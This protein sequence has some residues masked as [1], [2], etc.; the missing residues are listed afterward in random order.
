MERAHDSVST[1]CDITPM[2]QAVQAPLPENKEAA[3]QDLK[4]IEGN[5]PSLPPLDGG[6]G[7]LVILGAF[8]I[9]GVMQDMYE[10]IFQD[11]E[12]V[13]LKLS[14][15]GTIMEAM[16]NL[17]GLVATIILARFGMRVL[18]FSGSFLAVLGLEMAGFATQIWHLYLCQGVV[19]NTAPKWF[20]KKRGLAMGLASSGSGFGGLILPFILNAANKNPALGVGWAYRI[21]GFIILACCIGACLLVKERVKTPKRTKSLKDLFDFSVLKD[22]NFLLW[23]LGSMIGLC[24]FFVPFFFLPSY[25]RH[26]GLDPDQGSALIAVLSTGNLLGRPLVGF[27]ADKIGRLNADIIWTIICGLSSLLIWTFADSYGVLMAFCIVFGLFCGSYFTLL[28]PITLDIVG[29]DRFPT[30]LSMLLMSNIFSVFGPSI[31]SGIQ[32][33]VDNPF[34]VY[35]IFTGFTYVLG[36]LILL[37]LKIKMTKGLWTRI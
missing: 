5:D 36:G 11:E 30:A 16:V 29:I 35:K 27:T 6:R 22:I 1:V 28:S 37:A 21:L 12:N 15:A 7:W 2:D 13:Q 10:E 25:A 4:D 8:F 18:L 32:V 23:T 20:D 19:M 3:H 24:G 17:C 14:F 33:Q 31:A 34:L 26:I 9:Q